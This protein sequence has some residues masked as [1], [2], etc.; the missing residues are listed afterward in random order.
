[1]EREAVVAFYQN[2]NLAPVWLDKGVVNARA[3][4]VIARMKTADTDGLE[5]ADYKAPSFT[6]ATPEA[7]A[8]ADLKLTHVVL[9]FARHLQAGRFA[10]TRVSRNIELP[11]AA[12][13]AADVL[14]KVTAAA[15]AGKALDEFSPQQEPYRK[16]KAALADLRSKPNIAKGEGARQIELVVAN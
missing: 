2:R 1:K 8:E 3:T 9:T 13:D 5:P 11:Q 7:L 15:D 12:P 14:G 6:D 4:S 10:Y 16:L